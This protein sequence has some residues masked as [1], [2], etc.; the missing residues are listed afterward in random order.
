MNLR[1]DHVAGVFF[2]AAGLTVIALS[3]D[4]PVGRLSMPGAGFLPMLVAVLIIIL[5]ISLFFRA[6]ES[7][8]FSAINW[9]DA[10]HAAAVI[11]ITAA[12]VALYVSL[13][14]IITMILMMIALMVV[15]E[16]KNI[17]RAS[18]Y[19]AF[20]VVLTYLVFVHLLQSPLPGG[21]LGYF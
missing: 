1:A 5:G 6:S 17:V 11:L 13:G 7:H 9:D 15:I 8:P 10:K 18:L 19:S 2:V 3:G 21:V 12:A 16:R 4:L 14:F 20:V